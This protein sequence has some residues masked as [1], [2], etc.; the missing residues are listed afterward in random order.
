MTSAE[1]RA[2]AAAAVKQSMGLPDKS[3]DWTLEQRQA[4]NKALAAYI[5]ARPEQFSDAELRAAEAVSKSK[6]TGLEDEGFDVGMFVEET[7]K[8][9]GDALQSIGNGVLTVAKSAQWVIPVATAGVLLV[10]FVAFSKRQGVTVAV[11]GV[12]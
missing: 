8:P 10:L 1:N 12:K 3:A 2:A 9:A 5:S 4:Y 11:P 7:I 6:Y